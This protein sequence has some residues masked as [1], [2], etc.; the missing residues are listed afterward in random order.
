MINIWKKHIFSRL[1]VTF[2][3]LMIPLYFIGISIYNWGITTVKIEIS[4]SKVSQINVYMDNLE[5][6]IQRIKNQQSDCL[7]GD[8]LN[9]LANSHLFMD[10]YDKSYYML[11]LQQRLNAIKNSSVYIEN[12]FAIIPSIHKNIS[13][14]GSISDIREEDS[15]MISVIDNSTLSQITYINNELYINAAFPTYYANLKSI[16]PL[17]AILIK[18][19]SNELR[20]ALKQF[21]SY[22]GSGTLF[23]N[24]EKQFVLDL[25]QNN[26]SISYIEKYITNQLETQ[27]MGKNTISVNGEKYIVVY[28][29]SQFL[30]LTL[31]NFIP[32]SQM[33]QSLNKYRMWVWIF[34]ISSVIILVIFSYF[35]YRFIQRPLKKLIK[36]FNRLES[37]DLSFFIKHNYEDE[38]SYLYDHFNGMLQKLNLMIE[39]TYK[40]KIMVQ[41]AELKQLQAQINPHFLYNSFFILYTMTRRGE[42]DTLEKFALQIGEYFQFI[43]RNVNDEISLIREISHA[44]TYCDIQTIRFSNRIKVEFGEFLNTAYSY[45]K[46]PRLIIQPIIENAFEHGLENKEENGLL[47]VKFDILEHHLFIIVEDNGEEVSDPDIDE[48]NRRINEAGDEIEATGI[49]NIHRRIRLKFGNQSGLIVSR[50]SIGGL[51]VVIKIFIKEYEEAGHE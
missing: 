4:N 16:K 30:G 14:T 31:C 41:H 33:F 13:G 37:G 27:D 5:K 49:I 2:F 29:Y 40:Q 47:Q 7:L 22:N 6:E 51:K 26:N 39:Q 17:Y 9:R 10:D 1:I 48:I 44:Q 35:L 42:Y 43:T 28:K 24:P 20:K 25:S 12:A 8:D 18:I 45:L 38:F 15:E 19:S 34:S 21:N 3:I 46:V 50:G 32:E 11:K 23:L 36:A